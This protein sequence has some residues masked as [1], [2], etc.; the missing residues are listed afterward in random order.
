M[1][2][3]IAL[4]ISVVAL[5]GCDS[6]ESAKLVEYVADGRASELDVAFIAP[7]G[8]PA[9]SDTTF[10]SGDSTYTSGDT[11]FV[12]N[13]EPTWRYSFEAEEGDE[14]FLRVINRTDGSH[15]SAIIYVDQN[16]FSSDGSAE[17]FGVAQCGGTL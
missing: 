4:A 1:R 16:Y 9:P 10:V 6:T 2:V 12:L 15:V 17:P 7:P 5:I 14:L 13:V 11:T 8:L 3:V